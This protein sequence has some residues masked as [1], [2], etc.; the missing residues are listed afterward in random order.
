LTPAGK[1]VAERTDDERVD[2][3]WREPLDPDGPPITQP[4]HLGDALR[5]SQGRVIRA[6]HAYAIGVALADI[7]HTLSP[8][9]RHILCGLRMYFNF[10]CAVDNRDLPR[11]VAVVERAEE[12]REV[13]VALNLLAYV[14]T[15]VAYGRLDKFTYD[16][17]DELVRRELGPGDAD[18]V[19]SR[20][21]C[22]RRTLMRWMY[23]MNAE[24]MQNRFDRVYAVPELSSKDGTA[25]EQE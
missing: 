1:P 4:P 7:G 25:T 15:G 2:I 10:K 13:F 19:M 14:V 22:R 16:Q 17:A 11:A 6:R 23:D 8:G 24:D 12:Y 3:D 9:S 21:A 20:I 5:A 18:R